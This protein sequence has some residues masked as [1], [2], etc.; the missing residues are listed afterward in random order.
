MINIPTIALIIV[1]VLLSSIKICR[2]RTRRH[3][4]LGHALP[5][6]SDQASSSRCA[7]RPPGSHSLRVET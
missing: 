5:Q 4:R 6:P 7:H 3:F 2:I 1:V